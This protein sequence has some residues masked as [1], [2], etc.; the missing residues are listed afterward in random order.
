MSSK[1]KRVMIV[2]NS[3]MFL[4]HYIV[5]PSVSNNGEPIGGLQGT[6]KGLQKLVREIKPD[7]IVIC[8]DGPGGSRKRK[9]LN[10]GYKDGRSP[11]R[12][13]WNAEM[14]SESD[15]QDNKVWQMLRLSQYYDEMPI[16]QFLFPEIEAD[17]LISVVC[18]LE[19]LKDWEKVI[20]S[21]DKDFIQLCNE[22]TVLYRPI[23]KQVLTSKRVL[24]EYGIH[25]SNFALARAIA[26]DKSD[27]IAGVSGVGIK[28]VAKRIPFLKEEEGYSVTELYTYCEAMLL[29]GS[30]VKAYQSISDNKKLIE[31]N[32]KLM[33]L[34]IPSISLQVKQKIKNDVQS[35][36]L[37]WNKTR[38]STMMIRDGFGNWNWDTLFQTF[39]K[40]M[41]DNS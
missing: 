24:G 18:N 35:E 2:D 1:K 37:I 23:Q 8:F 7:K 11:I 33:Q 13:N 9:Q 32:Y 12:L 31:D 41:A 25:P 4:R 29:E 34:Y 6:L 14:M 3:N 5:D 22:N 19:S 39:N 17:D 30:T 36:K 26:G 20:V 16:H 40:I 38:F 27:N 15:K 21:S 10:K 28:T